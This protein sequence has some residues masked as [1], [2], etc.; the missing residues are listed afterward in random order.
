MQLGETDM[1]AHEPRQQIQPGMMIG[2]E[3]IPPFSADHVMPG[4]INPAGVGKLFVHT[5][6]SFLG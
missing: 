5:H 6:L 1:F 3:G 2:R 4:E